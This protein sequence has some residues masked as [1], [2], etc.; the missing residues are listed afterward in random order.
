MQQRLAT[1]VDELDYTVGE[2]RAVV[3]NIE[4]HRPPTSA[5]AR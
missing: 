2:I 3:F 1:A 5:D 4:I